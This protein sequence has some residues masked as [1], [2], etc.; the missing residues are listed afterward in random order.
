MIKMTKRTW[1]FLVIEPKTRVNF[2][3]YYLRKCDILVGG[4][5]PRLPLFK[6]LVGHSIPFSK[7][8]LR[9]LDRFRP[10][11]LVQLW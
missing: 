10:Y 5:R 3:T 9:S 1:I 4:R 6:L 8:T 7:A 11:Q 2:V